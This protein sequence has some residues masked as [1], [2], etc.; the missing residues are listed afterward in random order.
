M[1]RISGRGAGRAGIRR[2]GRGWAPSPSLDL[3]HGRH[4]SV[5]LPV[6]GGEPCGAGGPVLWFGP[7]VTEGSAGSRKTP[8]QAWAGALCLQ[9][10]DILE[11]DRPDGGNVLMGR[12]IGRM[13][14]GRL[15]CWGGSPQPQASGPRSD[16]AELEPRFQQGGLVVDLGAREEHLR[17]GGD[18]HP[19]AVLFHDL[20]MGVRS[21]RHMSMVYSMRAPPPFLMPRDQNLVAPSGPFSLRIC[22]SAAGV[23][24]RPCLAWDRETLRAH[25]VRVL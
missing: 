25:P 16:F 4:R 5:H 24:V 17:H 12:E 22:R 6:S 15:G 7:P 18:H 11:L 23:R 14:E 21:C 13:R 8:G 9:L 10:L 1:G 2:R 20:V 19:R 3:G